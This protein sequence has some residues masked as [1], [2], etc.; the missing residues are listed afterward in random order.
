MQ[1]KWPVETTASADILRLRR[2][3]CERSGF[4]QDDKTGKRADES[5]ADSYFPFSPSLNMYLI[6]GL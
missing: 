6:E 3:A 4:A 2:S 5:K 1:I